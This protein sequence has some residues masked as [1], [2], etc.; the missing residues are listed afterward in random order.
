MEDREAKQIRGLSWAYNN[1]SK[2][3]NDSYQ[4]DVDGVLTGKTTSFGTT[5]YNYSSR[6]E[7][8]RNRKGDGSN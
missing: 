7:R 2:D 3:G 1:S 6:G 8:N 5:T 4:F